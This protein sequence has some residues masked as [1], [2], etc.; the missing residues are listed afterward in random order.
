MC[1]H[2]NP[3]QPNPV[4]SVCVKFHH[5]FFCEFVV[6]FGDYLFNFYSFFSHFTCTHWS[7]SFNLC[8]YFLFG[9]IC[10][11]FVHTTSTTQVDEHQKSKQRNKERERERIKQAIFKL[12]EQLCTAFG[13]LLFW[14][15]I[16]DRTRLAAQR[17]NPNN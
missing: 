9:S 13:F 8:G 5:I 7:F 6:Y 4:R 3:S 14:C 17:K 15:V 16:R 1:M 2:I 12:F 10:D 11:L